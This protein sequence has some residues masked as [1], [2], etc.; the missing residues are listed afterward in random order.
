MTAI[1][2]PDVHLIKAPNPD[3]VK[4]NPDDVKVYLSLSRY[5]I[6]TKF[7]SKE[8]KECISITMMIQEISIKSN[9]VF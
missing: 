9:F 1:C 6:I 5:T 4:I 7:I 3:D 2:D 8:I